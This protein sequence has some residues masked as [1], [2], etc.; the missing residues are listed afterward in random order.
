MGHPGTVTEH[1][2]HTTWSKSTARFALYLLSAWGNVFR[3]C[4]CPKRFVESQNQYFGLEGR[5]KGSPVQPPAM[6]IDIFNWIR[7]LRAWSNLAWNVS[8]DG[9]STTSLGNLVPGPHHPH[10]EESFPYI[11]SK[12][13][14]F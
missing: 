11:Q 8:R 10:G 13:P 3:C 9:A 14:L 12:S 5:F 4:W 1:K 7:V 6:G 2:G